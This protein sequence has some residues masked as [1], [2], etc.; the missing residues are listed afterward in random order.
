[1][2]HALPFAVAYKLHPLPMPGYTYESAFMNPFPVPSRIAAAVLLSCALMAVGVLNLRDRLN[3]ADPSDGVLWVESEGALRSAGLKPGAG[4]NP[5]AI[6]P[7]DRLLSIDGAEVPDLGRYAELLYR[8]APGSWHTYEVAGEAGVRSVRLRLGARPLF[9]AR[10]GLKTLLAFLHLGIGFYV[11]W[12]TRA[13]GAGRHFFLVCLAAFVLWLYSYTPRLGLL[14]WTVYTLSAVAFLLLPAL[15]LHFCHR[16]PVASGPRPALLVYAPALALVA[17]HFL[18][19]TGHLAPLGLALTAGGSL[20]VDRVELLFFCAAFLA[21]GLRLLRLRRGN[22]DLVAGQQLKWIGYGTMAGIVPFGLAYG[23]PVLLGARPNLAMEASILSLALIPLAVGYALTDFR[24]MDVEKI[25]RGAAARLAA[26]GLLVAL[27]LFLVLVPGK[28]LERVAP[29]SLLPSMGLAALALALLFRPLG[30]VI[31]RGLERRFYRDRFEDR[32]TLLDF[33]RTLGS[34]IG[35]R[36]LSRRILERISGAFRIETAALLVDDPAHPGRLR[37]ADAIGRPP[38]ALR[39][40]F[41]AEALGAAEALPGLPGGPGRLYP[42]GAELEA[43]GFAYVQ[44]LEHRGRRVGAIALGPLPGGS[45]FSTEDLDLLT[46]LAKFGA[47]AV[48]NA[49]LLESAE[50]RA[51]E[52]ERMKRATENILE[53]I[54]VAVL[55]LEEDGRIRFCNRAFETLYAVSRRDIAGTPVDNLFSPDFIASLRGG[56]SGE[57]WRIDS[58]VNLF[59]LRLDNLEGERRIVNLGL[60]PLCDPSERGVLLVLDDI[61]EKIALEDQLLQ[62]EKL[63]SIG[64]LAAGIA[65]EINTPITGISSYAQML[66][67]QAGESDRQ[68]PIL[69]KIEKQSFRAS[70]IVNSLLNFSRL[71]GSTFNPVD[72]NRLIADSLALLQHQFERSGIRVES[73]LEDSLPPVYGNTGKLQQVLVNLFLNARDAMPSGGE[74]AI[75]TGMRESMVVVEISDTGEGIPRENLNRIFDPFF[76]TKAMGKG[77]GLGLAVSYGIVQEHGGR[78]LVDTPGKGTRFMLKFPARLQ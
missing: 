50:S 4:P 46:A 10:D 31:E 77:T 55:A 69:E 52:L 32:A 20:V 47:I 63:S 19:I 34:D 56:D 1:M 18:W 7:G 36:P 59:K 2:A 24:L 13:S 67:E 74:L 70:E 40:L 73:D 51:G 6:H 60:I 53:S 71:S 12:R 22:R 14:D 41:R 16:F 58:P 11:L 39:P 25:A 29:H 8:F 45:H 61:T 48:D 72:L 62:A 49:R 42:A 37:P 3:W 68:R 26:A 54:D 28:G 35:L 23:L 15:F 5:P 76:T 43:E 65:H 66:L 27:Y 64:L 57:G 33:A 17:F 38:A 30:R 75:R 44:E 21:G 9:S 78:I